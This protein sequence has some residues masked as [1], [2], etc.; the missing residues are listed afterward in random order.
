MSVF[1]FRQFSVTQSHSAM[2]I[3]TDSMV[4]GAFIDAMHKQNA[5]DIGTGTG[6]LSLMVA[7]KNPELKILA[8]EIEA[9]AFQEAKTNLSESIFKEQLDIVHADF[10]GFAFGQ[11][12][13]LIFSN[14]PYFENSSKSG[15][16]T[17]DLARHDDHL[18]LHSLFEK[19][20]QLL[21]DTGDFWLILPNLTMD[22]YS[23]AA[24]ENKLFPKRE[25]SV[26]GK[27][28]QLVRKITV[29]SKNQTELISEDFVIRNADNTYTEAYKTLTE[30]YHFN[31]LK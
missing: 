31:V 23:S 14:P 6:V 1:K 26:F 20:S 11:T 16:S 21:S 17:R 15:V 25:I 5:L 13:D 28:N 27:A 24:V 4:F 10:L 2:K 19:V 8:V 9:N 18:P 3:G 29:F 30:A 12:F 7:Q 22:Q